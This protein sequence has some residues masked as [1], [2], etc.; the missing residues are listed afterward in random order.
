MPSILGDPLATKSCSQVVDYHTVSKWVGHGLQGQVQVWF[1]PGYVDTTPMCHS[2]AALQGGLPSDA[3]MQCTCTAH[4]GE[5]LPIVVKNNDLLLC[6]KAPQEPD[7]PARDGGGEAVDQH[8]RWPQGRGIA[9][10]ACRAARGVQRCMAHMAADQL[11]RSLPSVCRSFYSYPHTPVCIAVDA[12]SPWPSG[13][14]RTA[15]YYLSSGHLK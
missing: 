11:S 2:R 7:T 5:A 6:R 9:K 3:H 10:P 8:E 15:T 1:P 12:L 14:H 13:V 4:L